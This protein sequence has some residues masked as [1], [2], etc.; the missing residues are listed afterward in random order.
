MFPL[1]FAFLSIE[2]F[3]T[4][5]RGSSDGEAPHR[6]GENAIQV[7]LDVMMGVFPYGM[8]VQD[9]KPADFF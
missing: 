6:S 2:R 4:R 1:L 8:T 3:E 9:M 5:G 7:V